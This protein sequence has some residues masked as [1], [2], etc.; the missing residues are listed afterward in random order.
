MLE[1][2]SAAPRQPR[3]P[4]LGWSSVFAARLPRALPHV[5]QLPH[6]RLTTSGRAALWQAL[7]GLELGPEGQVLVP[8]YHCPTLVAPVVA[9]GLRPV[10]Y[11]IDGDGLPALSL[12]AQGRRAQAGAMIVPHYFGRARSLAAVR[13]WCDAHG[14]VLIEDCAHAF[15]GM[16]GERPVGAW[17]DFATASLTKFLP[18]PEAGLL[19]SAHGPLRP[20]ALRGPG[21]RQQLKACLEVLERRPE[22]G[23]GGAMVALLQRLR[24]GAKTQRPVAAPAAPAGADADSKAMMRACDMARVAQRPTWPATALARGLPLGGSVQRRRANFDLYAEQ[25]AAMPGT[26]ALWPGQAGAAVPYVYPLWVDEPESLYADLRRRGMA[27]LRWDRI[28]PGTPVLAGDHGPLWSRHVLQ[29]LCHQDLASTDI[30]RTAQAIRR[31]A[32]AAAP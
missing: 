29:L 11:P 21:M 25:L 19:A 14:T 32:G 26:R 22:G 18:V 10:F 3:G 7:A 6:R 1:R 13:R 5:M 8:T 2:T 12:M 16:A 23:L 24:S 4:V 15:F 17:G 20:T 31:H 28:W 9:L 30:L 27:V